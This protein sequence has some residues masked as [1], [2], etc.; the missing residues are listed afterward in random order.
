VAHDHRDRDRRGLRIAVAITG[1]FLCVEIAGG[2]LSGSLALLA[3]AGHMATDAAALLLAL[4]ALRMAERA[5]TQA[6]TYGY[7]RTE[8]LAALAN[9]VVL[10]LVALYVA[11]EATLRIPAP[12]EIEGGLMLVVAVAGLAANLSSRAF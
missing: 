11:Y 5:P 12:R 10:V 4:F 6:K 9:G 1:I 3:D 2:I 8:I 7:R